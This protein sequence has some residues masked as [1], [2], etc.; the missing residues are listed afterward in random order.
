[1][2]NPW[3]NHRSGIH[4]CRQKEDLA[5]V[6]G[7]KY[8]LLVSDGIDNGKIPTREVVEDL[9]ENN[10]VLHIIHIGDI[11]DQELKSKLKEMASITG[12]KYF[13]YKDHENVIPTLQ[14]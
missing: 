6:Y 4:Y 9:K 12:G 10:I 7:K 3:G 14:Q 5:G 13:T 1:M 8:V 11:Q 2:L